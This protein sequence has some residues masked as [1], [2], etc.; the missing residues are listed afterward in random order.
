MAIYQIVFIYKMIAMNPQL[1]FMLQQAIQA[2][3]NRNFDR[4]DSILKKVIQI[5]ANNLPALH[6]L[7]L[8]KASQ[9]NYRE[10]VDFLSRA[11]S[12]HPSDASIQYNLAKAL[13]DCGQDIESIPHHKMAVQLAPN[14]PEAWLNYGNT[15]SKLCYHDDAS[16]HYDQ[17]LSLKPDYVEAWFN[18]ANAMHELKRYDEAITHYD[19]ALSL[20][21]DYAEA[22]SNKGLTLVELNF[23]NEAIAA[24]SNAIELDDK[25]FDAYW[26]KATAQLTIG[27]FE[28]GWINYEYRWKRRETEYYR[29]DDILLLQNLDN[30]SQK[31]VLVWCD[32]FYGDSIQFIRY[33]NE[34]V[35]L[36]AI[37]FLEAH[38]PLKDIFKNSF[39]ECICISI[40]SPVPEVDYQISISS[41]PLIFNTTFQ[42]IPKSIPYL[43]CSK[44]A[45]DKWSEILDLESNKINIAVA[46]S[47]NTTHFKNDKKRP[48]KLEVFKPL[49]QVANL[50]LVQK[51]IEEVDKAFLLSHPE[52]NFLG[53]QIQNF[54]DTAAIIQKM[55]LT[56]SIDTSIAHLSGAIGKKTWV[57]VSCSPDWRWMLNKEDSPWYLTVKL[58]RQPTIDDWVSVIDKVNSDLCL[59][60]K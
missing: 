33:I 38:P 46:C 47:G 31:R 2:F 36:N 29:H 24:Y 19:Q 34:L 11:A 8:I 25:F 53:N 21:P 44:Q 30:I 60:L 54:D 43:K 32:Q 51:N 15:V 10:A 16:T 26:N 20:K 35:S 56:I 40:G 17:A 3:Q 57:L 48:I 55:D 6:V 27:N 23:H 9:A 22:W 49:L 13:S 41:L 12:I 50:F 58:Y 42:K 28:E 45:F 5:D 18:K 59:M 37:I 1:Q 7:G 39:P 4:A 52:I 14:N